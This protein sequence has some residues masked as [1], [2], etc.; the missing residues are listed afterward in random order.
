MDKKVLNII[1][2]GENGLEIS[3]DIFLPDP[4]MT[5]SRR[6]RNFDEFVKYSNQLNGLFQSMPQEVHDYVCFMLKRILVKACV[7]NKNIDLDEFVS[8]F[9][10][11]AKIEMALE[12]IRNS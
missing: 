10:S 2:N 12:K 5:E 3:T 11:D 1:F 8:D 9:V 4:F 6:M 7:F